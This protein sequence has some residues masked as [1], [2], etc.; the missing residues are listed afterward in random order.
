MLKQAILIGTLAAGLLLTGASEP[1]GQSKLVTETYTV[2]AG[3]TLWNIA[4]Q[5]MDKNT[6]GPRDI[7]EFYHGII[8]LNHDTVFK[9]RPPAL[10][11]PGDELKI[12][13]WVSA[14]E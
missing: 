9:G 2:K 14:D 6:Y 4:G 1:S 12:N 8:E 11:Q 10:I 7:R 13:Y 5:Y 3:D